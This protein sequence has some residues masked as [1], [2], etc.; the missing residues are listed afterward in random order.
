MTTGCFLTVK[1]PLG[2]SSIPSK[3]ALAVVIW[4][5][6]EI[7]THCSP[8]MGVGLAI[9]YK[10]GLL[11]NWWEDRCNDGNWQRE[12]TGRVSGEDGKLSQKEAEENNRRCCLGASWLPQLER[13]SLRWRIPG[14]DAVSQHCRKPS[15]FDVRSQGC[16][17]W[18]SQSWLTDQLYILMGSNFDFYFCVVQYMGWVI[19]FHWVSVKWET[20]NPPPPQ[21]KSWEKININLNSVILL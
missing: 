19:L 8:P 17:V 6:N 10:M 21:K 4:V 15:V 1:Y 5:I 11:C 18:N 13:D 3:G 20:T 12:T 14:Q 16:I 9:S 7:P 2:E